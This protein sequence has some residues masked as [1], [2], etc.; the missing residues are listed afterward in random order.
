MNASASLR[1]PY[2]LIV[3]AASDIGLALAHEYAKTG[4]SLALA[5]RN[6][7]RMSADAADLRIRHKTDV[8]LIEFDIL[9]TERYAEFFNLL[10]FTPGVAVCVVGLLGDQESAQTNSVTAN[11]IMRSNYNCPALMMDALAAQMEARGSGTLIGISSVAGDRGRAS[12]YIYGSA[13]AGFTAFLSGLRN[14]LAKKGVHVITVKP[15]FVNTRMTAGLKLPKRLTAEPGDVARAI[16]KAAAAR[17][18]VIYVYPVWR[19]IM[20]IIRLLPERIFKTTKL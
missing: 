20:T 11:L 4:V 13:K 1:L 15:G 14:R 6:V 10:G 16:A 18:D 19:L 17:R 5:A 12:N 7:A 2:V 3:G 8:R 9:D